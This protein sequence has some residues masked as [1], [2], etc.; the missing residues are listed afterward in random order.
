MGNIPR[1]CPIF[2]GISPV[3]FAGSR[4]KW[5]GDRVAALV[6]HIDSNKSKLP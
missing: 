5:G 1:L 4:P 3:P 6:R 2:T